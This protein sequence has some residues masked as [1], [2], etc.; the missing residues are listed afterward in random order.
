MEQSYFY[1]CLTGREML[2]SI[3][4]NKGLLGD[5]QNSKLSPQEENQAMLA[6][7]IASTGDNIISKT[8]WGAM[9]VILAP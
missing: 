5:D 9:S 4:A 1:S 7:I 8:L 6:A 3:M 2:P